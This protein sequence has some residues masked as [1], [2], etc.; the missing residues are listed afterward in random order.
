MH[1]TAVRGDYRES[2]QLNGYKDKFFTV[3]RSCQAI[4][5]VFPL[6][7]HDEGALDVR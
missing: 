4:H 1:V 7:Y 6:R 3:R 5:A 2:I